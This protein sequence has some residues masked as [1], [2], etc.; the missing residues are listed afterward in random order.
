MTD[1]LTPKQELFAQ[2]VASGKTGA[3]AYRVAYGNGK[4]S[5]VQKE[6]QRLMAH[7]RVA[8]RIAELRAPA[9]V[10]VAEAIS[11]DL[12]RTL[13]ETAR[14]AFV[15]VRKV[16]NEH[17]NLKPIHEW[18]ADTAGAV[19]SV[20]VVE[21]FGKGAD[22]LGQ[23]GYTKKVRFHNKVQALDQLTK[24][25]GGYKPVEDGNTDKIKDIPRETLKLMDARLSELAERD[26]VA[27]RTIAGRARKSAR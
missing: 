1:Q 9:I 24:H 15:D 10:A 5:T 21:L 27:G 25:F 6:A 8:P 16:F 22:G 7:P 13:F 18:D 23:I 20:E 4:A 11:V 12:V 19:A 26:R 2:G 3:D 17:G 14:V